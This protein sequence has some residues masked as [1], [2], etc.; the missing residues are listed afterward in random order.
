LKRHSSAPKSADFAVVLPVAGQVKNE[1]FKNLQKVA[2]RVGLTR[3][4]LGPRPAGA[5]RA[6]KIAPCDFVEPS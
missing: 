6:S 5:L 1:V 2:K 4:I 3:A